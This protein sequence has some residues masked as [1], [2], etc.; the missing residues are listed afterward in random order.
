MKHLNFCREFSKFEAEKTF[1]SEPYMFKNNAIT[2]PTQHHNYHL[3]GLI[4]NWYFNPRMG[5]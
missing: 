4:K 1:K 5:K 2:I 3:S